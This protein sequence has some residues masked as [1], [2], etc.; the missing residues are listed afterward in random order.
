[1]KY[2]VEFERSK[3]IKDCCACPFYKSHTHDF[4]DFDF[5]Q[6]YTCIITCKEHVDSNIPEWCPL[7]EVK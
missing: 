4:G 5:V 1:M 7:E 3:E 6:H 2:K